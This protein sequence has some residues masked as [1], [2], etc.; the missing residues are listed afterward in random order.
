MAL[1][2]STSEDTV[3]GSFLALLLIFVF[4]FSSITSRHCMQKAAGSHVEQQASLAVMRGRA[5]ITNAR[6][7]CDHLAAQ[8]TRPA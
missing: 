1:Q 5:S 2:L 8:F 7:L 4:Q 6:Q 3:L